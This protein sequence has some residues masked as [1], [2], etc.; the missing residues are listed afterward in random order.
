MNN[1]ADTADFHSQFGYN[2]L[3]DVSPQWR[4]AVLRQID[5]LTSRLAPDA[6]ILEIGCGRGLALR[7]LKRRGYAARGIEISPAAAQAARSN[8]LDVQAA[9]FMAPGNPGRYDAVFLSHVLE[10]MPD[11]GPLLDKVASA[12]KPAGVVV[13]AQ[14]N[15]KGL[16]PRLQ[17]ERW[18]GWTPDQHYWHFTPKGLGA[19]LASRG[20]TVLR[21][22]QS[23]LSHGNSPLSRLGPLVGM[24]DQFHLLATI[25]RKGDAQS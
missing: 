15:W 22:E 24:G 11:I 5:L 9:D 23:S 7:E 3:D 1:Q 10:H 19:V 21:T 2:T 16:V 20:W 12:L 13:F 6:A 17:R 25:S 8:G 14:T 18:Y 4:G